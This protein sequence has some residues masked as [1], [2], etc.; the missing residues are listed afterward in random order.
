MKKISVNYLFLLLFAVTISGCSLG[1]DGGNDPLIWDFNSQVLKI[2]IVDQDGHS[3][4]DPNTRQGDKRLKSI[5]F[6]W[7]DETYRYEGLPARQLR[8][9]PEYY[10]GVSL[11]RSKSSYLLTF[12]EFQPHYRNAKIEIEIPG[13]GEF[14]VRFTY[15]ASPKGTNP[16][17]RKSV[18]VNGV[19]VNNP[20]DP[21]QIRLVVDRK[22]WDNYSSNRHEATYLPVTLYFVPSYNS[23]YSFENINKQRVAV[24]YNNKRYRYNDDYYDED[25]YEVGKDPIYLNKLTLYGGKTSFLTSNSG[26]WGNTFFAFGPFDPAKNYEK[27]KLTFVLL[28]HSFEIEF[29]A[30]LDSEG[31]PF[32]DATIISGDNNGR[33][34]KKCYFRNGP[35]VFLPL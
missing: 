34:E 16:N 35:L 8:A 3:L 24:L 11:E 14:D 2:E 29:T 10:K 9:V 19:P 20:E 12:G 5:S 28:D 31:I 30:K 1:P 27:E 6:E 26:Y 21:F 13:I 22:K 7:D 17:I 15:T 18:T 33:T 25:D 32:Y 4:I 23:K